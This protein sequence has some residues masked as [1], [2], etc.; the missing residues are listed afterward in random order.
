MK[1]LIQPDKSEIN[2]WLVSWHQDRSLPVS[3]GNMSAA[4]VGNRIKGGIEFT[5]PSVSVLERV[6]AIRLHLDPNT[7]NNGPLKVLPGTHKLG[8]LCANEIAKLSRER[9]VTITGGV[10][11]AMVMRQLLVH[12]SSKVVQPETRRVLHIVYA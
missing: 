2:N 6:L 7:T 5:Q 11:S 10:G 4:K 1:Q 12:A 3:A 9:A 8:V